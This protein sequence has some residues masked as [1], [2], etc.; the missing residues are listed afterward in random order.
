MNTS[1]KSLLDTFWEKNSH[2]KIHLL[3]QWPSILGNLARQACIYKINE[4]SLVIMVNNASLMHELHA[5]SHVLIKKINQTLDQ[6]RIRRLQ[7]KQMISKNFPSSA[8]HITRTKKYKL[9]EPTPKERT[10]LN[11]ISDA[12][13]RE[14]LE[15]FLVRCYQE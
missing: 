7:W 1:I 6:P 13:L 9:V 12:Q 2:W 4:D 14:L 10:A 3:R 15:K 11:Q 5:L 8:K